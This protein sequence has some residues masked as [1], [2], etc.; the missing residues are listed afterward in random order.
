MIGTLALRTK[1]MATLV[2][3]RPFDTSTLEGRAQ[4]R[5]RR[6]A[7]SAFASAMAKAISVAT[8]LISVPL[9]LH[10]LGSERY[11]MWITMSSLIT[12]LSFA[13]LGIGNGVL[14]AVASAN[15]RDD[16]LAIRSYVSSGIFILTIVAALILTLFALAYRF[17]PWYELF[18]V[19]S[20]IARRESGPALA[21]LVTCFALAI[22]VGIVQR[23]QMG[24]QRGFMAS[25][26]QCVS[27]CLG[28]LG[29]LIAI[30]AE[31]GLPLLS[32][33]FVG[34]PLIA[35]LIN[36]IVFF[37][38]LQPDIAPGFRFV[39]SG[40][41]KHVARTGTL[42][43]V[44]Q[45]VV[46]IAYTSNSII[47]AQ[48]LGAAAV[49]SYAVPERMFSII[50][51]LLGMILTPLWPAYGEAIAR[52]DF[53]WVRRTFKLSMLISI[54]MAAAMSTVLVVCGPWLLRVWVGHAIAASSLLLIAFGIWKVLE[55]GGNALAMFLNGAN[56]IRSQVVISIL[57]AVVAISLKLLLVS[58]LG[59]PGVV[60][61]TVIAFSL[62]VI[63]PYALIVSKLLNDIAPA[64]GTV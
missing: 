47:I 55:A 8:G 2:R 18:N 41:A 21:V 9:T 11:G 63:T 28:L 62:C 12:M 46:A 64:R 42:F 13:D 54:G 43:L 57:F 35:S 60:W 45:I 56:V 3:L 19:Q 7:L 5:H 59:I 17:V 24:L 50:T 10:Y 61:A 37:G 33:A 1:R 27:S 23:V 4:E 14:S 38:F 39:S 16:R 48:M 30:K 58:I 32:L 40:A 52:K 34:A 49:A 22:P 25:L 15:G 53:A 51:M 31:L 26:W 29:V 6:M 36:S 44:L 20:D